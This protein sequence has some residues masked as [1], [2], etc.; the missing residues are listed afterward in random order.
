MYTNV[1]VSWIQVL[2]VPLIGLRHK[3]QRWEAN[4][5]VGQ[6]WLPNTFLRSYFN[7]KFI[8]L[9]IRLKRSFLGRTLYIY[10]WFLGHCKIRWRLLKTTP[11]VHR[12]YFP[13]PYVC[14]FNL[15]NFIKKEAMNDF[16][17]YP[18]KTFPLFSCITNG[19]R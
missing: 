12:S 5:R 11:C 17:V 1:C 14:K 6:F 19:N 9:V 8:S 2:S 3:A 4:L 10:I 13:L 7:S 15:T 18:F 16:P